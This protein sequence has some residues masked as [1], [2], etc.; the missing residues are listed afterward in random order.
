MQRWL[1]FTLSGLFLVTLMVA[2]VIRFWVVSIPEGLRSA[3]FTDA[4]GDEMFAE[5]IWYDEA[6]AEVE[7]S[8]NMDGSESWCPY[9]V[10]AGTGSVVYLSWGSREFPNYTNVQIQLP[11]RVRRWQKFDLK[12]AGFNRRLL[13]RKSWLNDDLSALTDS[14]ISM[15]RFMGQIGYSLTPNQVGFDGSLTILGITKESVTIKLPISGATDFDIEGK[16]KVFELARVP[17]PR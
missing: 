7:K 14:E 3:E 8:F 13:A 10:E 5:Y 17:A 1:R 16:T 6:T 11:E 4:D 9:N 12:P 15:F 2:L